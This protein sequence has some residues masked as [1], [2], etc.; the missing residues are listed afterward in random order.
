MV[1][2]L[3]VAYCS[4]CRIGTIDA[5]GLCGLCGAPQRPPS[6]GSRLAEAG[7]ALLETVLRPDFLALI[8]VVG[9]FLLAAVV[10][11][12]GSQ[13][14]AGMPAFN[15]GAFLS[16]QATLAAARQDPLG[17]FLRFLVPALVQGLLFGL[18]LL[19]LLMFL[20]R[21]RQGPRPGRADRRSMA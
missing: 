20:R 11:P 1:Y 17:A 10:I 16:P 9:I 6:R 2:A 7:G 15:P 3:D 14:P 13:P 19:S 4:R 8:A 18:L 5:Q 12:A 21:R